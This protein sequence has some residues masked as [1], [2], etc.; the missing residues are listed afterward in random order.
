MFMR[1]VKV[2]LSALALMVLL[3]CGSD[4]DPTTTGGD[5]AG[6]ETRTDAAT[7]GSEDASS[8]EERDSATMTAGVDPCSLLEASEVEPFFGASSSAGVRSGTVC[9][10]KNASGGLGTVTVQVE[11]DGARIYEHEKDLLGVSEELSDVGDEAFRSGYV[12][13]VRVG[14]LFMSV[15]VGPNILVDIPGSDGVIELAKKAVARLP[16]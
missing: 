16:R 10:W 6:T 7:S 4:G 2:S 8:S 12:V 14:D 1:N 11:D 9:Q 15:S 5:D 3:G 13:C